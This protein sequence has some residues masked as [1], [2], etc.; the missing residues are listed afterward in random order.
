[1]IKSPSHPDIAIGIDVGGTFTDIFALDRNSGTV[2]AV[3]KLP[4]TPD[5]PANAAV[6]GVDRFVERTKMQASAIFHGTTVGTNTLIEK[7][8][9]ITALITTKG[10]RD[11]LAL[12]HFEQLS[13][14]ETAQELGLKE[15][16]ASQRYVRAL[17]KLEGI[18]DSMP[19]GRGD[20]LS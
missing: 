20:P 11:V 14:A 4:S 19:G 8:G 3:F 12:R 13:N 1:M 2:A 17:R 15:G 9:A 16:A 10:F 18:L 6:Q 7:R 5:N